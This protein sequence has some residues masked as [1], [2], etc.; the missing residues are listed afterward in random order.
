MEALYAPPDSACVDEYFGR[1]G[2]TTRN[3]QPWH[4]YASTIKE[5]TAAT[6]VMLLKMAR[7]SDIDM[8]TNAAKLSS[9]YKVALCE[10]LTPQGAPPHRFAH[11]QIIEAVSSASP[12]AASSG[13]TLSKKKFESQR[14]RPP[15]G[16][17]LGHIELSNLKL[18]D[19]I[20]QSIT[21]SKGVPMKS[22]GPNSTEAV[23][24]LVFSWV[25]ATYGSIHVDMAFCE[26][27][28]TLLSEKWPS[29]KPWGKDEKA[30]PR[31]WTQII[32]NRFGNVREKKGSNYKRMLTQVGVASVD[33]SSPAK[34]L[35][36]DGFTMEIKES[37]RS[38]FEPSQPRAASAQQEA[39]EQPIPAGVPI[40]PKAVAVGAANGFLPLASDAAAGATPTQTLGE[41]LGAAPAQTLGGEHMAAGQA[42]Q[43]SRPR[44]RVRKEGAANKNQQKGNQQKGKQKKGQPAPTTAAQ[45]GNPD[46]SSDDDV[47]LNLKKPWRNNVVS[48]FDSDP[49]SSA[50]EEELRRVKTTM[51]A[52]EAEKAA[53]PSS[54]AAPAPATATGAAAAAAPTAAAAL[55]G[56]HLGYT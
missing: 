21:H 56:I 28:D 37:K 15:L 44:K 54:A 34:K 29:L 30:R 53:P 8:A 32:S 33:L 48:D 50:F 11:P 25:F 18:P 5:I 31:T 1:I 6:N 35:I 55:P 45:K 20:V 51:D 16:R 49:D 23:A 24:D 3:E 14:E 46:D 19:H 47:P 40:I 52:K 39:S 41:T 17:E 7:D 12:A 9:G 36:D 26:R 27:M 38:M 2:T 42:G 4:A 22:R 10:Y 43:A 13:S